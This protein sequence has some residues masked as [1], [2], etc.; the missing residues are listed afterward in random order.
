MRNIKKKR[1]LLISCFFILFFCLFFAFQYAGDCKDKKKA[2]QLFEKAKNISDYNQ[3]IKLYKESIDL[4][5]SYAAHYYMGVAFMQMNR[6]K[7]AKAAFLKALALNTTAPEVYLALGDACME[8]NDYGDALINYKTGLSLLNKP[9]PE[10]EKRLNEA[11]IKVIQHGAD[12]AFIKKVIKKGLE[13]KRSL[14]SQK[15]I[16]VLPSIDIRVEFDFDKANLSETGRKQ[17]DQIGI[18]ITGLYQERTRA[19]GISE[20]TTE[21]NVSAEAAHFA[22]KLIGHTDNRGNIAYNLDLSVR[23]A[24]A[25]K[26]FLASKYGI[27]EKLIAIQGRGKSEPLIPNAKTENEHA[28]NRRVEIVVIGQ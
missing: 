15:E 24:R 5:P 12:A 19:I 14:R 25:V 21:D 4:C 9:I 23:R 7:E 26:S 2:G 3:K 20:D 16:Q 28:V 17:A 10:Y 8:L 27:D 11:R 22:F 1:V 13:V 6:F 18:A